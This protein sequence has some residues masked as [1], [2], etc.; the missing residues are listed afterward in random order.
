MATMEPPGAAE[1]DSLSRAE[2]DISSNETASLRPREASPSVYKSEAQ[3]KTEK[4]WWWWEVGASLLSMITIGLVV[5]ILKMIDD[6]PLDAWRYSIRPNSLISILTTI[7]KSAMMALT[8]SCL[9]QLKWDHFQYSPNP[10]DH[11]QIY[12]EASRGPWGSFLLLCTGRLRVVTAWGLALVTLF[13][14]AVEPSAQQILETSTRHSLLPNVTA[15]IGIAKNYTS[16]G[17][18]S[19]SHLQTAIASGISGSV[20]PVNLICPPP[21]TQCSWP[22]FSTLAVCSS[23]SDLTNSA[24]RDCTTNG[25]YTVCTYQFPKGTALSMTSMAHDDD[26]LLNSSGRLDI[27]NDV[28]SVRLDGIRIPFTNKHGLPTADTDDPQSFSMAW[29]FCIKTYSKVLASPNGVHTVEYTSVPLL[30]NDS[31]P[32]GI[33]PWDSFSNPSSDIICKLTASAQTGLWQQLRDLLTRELLSHFAGDSLTTDFSVGEF[34]LFADLANM[35]RNIEETLS[36]QI[37]SS[38]PGDNYDAEMWPGQAFYE[39]TY[40]K[41]HWSWIALPVAE[42]LLAASLLAVS[43]GVTRAQPL[44][45]SSALALLYHGLADID[46]DPDLRGDWDNHLEDLENRAR[47]IDVELKTDANGSLKFVKAT[48]SL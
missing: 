17:L 40:W 43:I 21:S 16:K 18:A 11:L 13:A 28:P 37:R 39:E 22:P 3:K 14:L 19:R 1:L 23:F 26:S 20:P 2:E 45:K 24:Q 5:P 44:F 47:Y 6:R 27:L 7:S 48:P 36:N 34:M 9:S 10:L 33:Q 42:V 4:W 25:Y 32:P 46:Q 31:V 38:S 12:D 35:T 8:A 30:R 41:V 29:N 15:Q